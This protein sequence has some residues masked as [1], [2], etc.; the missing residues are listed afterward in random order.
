[1]VLFWMGIGL[2]AAMAGITA[3]FW[4]SLPPQ[5]PWFYSLPWGEKQ[6]IDKMWLLWIFLGMGIT[7]LLTRFVA[8]WA[9][10]GDSTVQ[11]TI[12]IG[13]FVAAV[14][15]AASFARIMIIFLNI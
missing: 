10:K 3:I 15:M 1:M 12:M 14:L 9:G 2:V 5:L 4:N 13:G 6:L 11:T 8:R 7:L